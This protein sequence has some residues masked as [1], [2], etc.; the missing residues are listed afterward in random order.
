M[1]QEHLTKVIADRR[2]EFN[3]RMAKQRQERL[4]WNWDVYK[5][6]AEHGLTQ[7]QLNMINNPYSGYRQYGD[8][9]YDGSGWGLSS[10]GSM[11]PYG[12]TVTR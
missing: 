1:Q 2:A 5:F 9:Y 10:T 3:K 7:T 8:S 11:I 6:K 12:T 4:K